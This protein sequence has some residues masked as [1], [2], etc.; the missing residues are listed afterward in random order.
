MVPPRPETAQA[1]EP[2]WEAN[3]DAK[4]T[5]S[6]TCEEARRHRLLQAGIIS[7][8]ITWRREGPRP[9]WWFWPAQQPTEAEARAPVAIAEGENLITFEIG[10]SV[11]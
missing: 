11:Q 9:G 1:A 3:E 7:M 4:D 10:H 8:G 6:V 2:H 5:N